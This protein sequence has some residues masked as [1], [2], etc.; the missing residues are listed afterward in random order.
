M[1]QEE[2]IFVSLLIW[3]L[4]KDRK[5]TEREKRIEDIF[6]GFCDLVWKGIW[7]LVK[8]AGVPAGILYGLS[9]I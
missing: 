6:D 5:P 9:K 8:Y 2:F 4:V 7:R 1:S 3:Y